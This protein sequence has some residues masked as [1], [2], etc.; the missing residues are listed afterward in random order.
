MEFEITENSLM[1]NES[2]I[3]QTLHDLKDMGSKSILMILA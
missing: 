1:K 2:Y 3:L